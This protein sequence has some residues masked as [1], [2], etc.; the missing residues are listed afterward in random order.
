M[1]FSF[2]LFEYYVFRWL[3][4]AEYSS[5]PAAIA[6]NVRENKRRNHV[7]GLAIQPLHILKKS[8]Y[9]GIVSPQS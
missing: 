3:H 5:I 7:I 9:I 1:I 6:C 2:I 8:S 4:H